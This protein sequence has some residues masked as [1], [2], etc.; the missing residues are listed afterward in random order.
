MDESISAA[1]TPRRTAVDHAVTIEGVGTSLPPFQLTHAQHLEFARQQGTL[2]EK[3]LAT[4]ARIMEHSEIE[5]RG[6]A[7]DDFTEMLETD[8]DRILARF[9]RW[10]VTLSAQA[11]ERGLAAAY[12][13]AEE[14]TYLAVT[15]CT[16]YL[17]P[18]LSSYVAE[19]CG[20]P[21][22]VIR[23]DIVGMGCG[24]AVPALEQAC[25]HLAA[26]PD[27]VAVVVS[28]EICSAA[29]YLGDEVELI[30]SNSIFGDGSAA[31]V[32]RGKRHN[33]V[34]VNGTAPHPRIRGFESLLVPEWRD[35]LRFRTE[36]GHLRNVLSREVPTRA[37]EACRT[38]TDKLLARYSLDTAKVDHWVIHAGGKAVLDSI[39]W[40]LKLP[41]NALAS[42]RNV[43][44]RC[45][46]MSS[47][48]VLF[49]LDETHREVRPKKGQRAVLSSFGAGF[50]AHAALLE[51]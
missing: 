8:H 38:I 13:R 47:P 33:G 5:T 34:S 24:A 37:G 23:V 6:I 25:Q 51:Y 12:V 35:G 28:T 26:N 21:Q 16:G 50:A 49:V 30:V 45:G 14:V 19:R 7:L 41:T 10:G 46:N 29:M 43:M 22:D 31:A 36:G 11:L 15:T 42:S 9:E 44:R 4:Y 2:S 39:E 17:C 27:G 18:G 1:P 48:T 40:A 20:L 32:L 3:T